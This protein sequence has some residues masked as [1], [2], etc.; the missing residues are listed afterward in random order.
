M[1]EEEEKEE[2]IVAFG[3]FNAI[4]VNGYNMIPASSG[5]VYET[6]ANAWVVPYLGAVKLSDENI[7]MELVDYTIQ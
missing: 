5:G 7:T 1:P 3:K 6:I 4:K 2:V